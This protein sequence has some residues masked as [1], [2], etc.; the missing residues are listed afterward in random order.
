MG[1]WGVQDLSR[2]RCLGCSKLGCACGFTY[3]V[4]FGC[5]CWVCLGFPWGRASASFFCTIRES[6]SGNP[7]QSF[8]I[9][10]EGRKLLSCQSHRRPTDRPTVIAARATHQHPFGTSAEVKCALFLSHAIAFLPRVHH[11]NLS[12]LSP[13]C[14]IET[15]RNNKILARM[16][17]Y[18]CNA[19][20][21][22]A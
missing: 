14:A 4:C 5:V 13:E 15:C 16:T 19:Y 22:V 17:K 1:V 3:W 7:S 6:C 21:P 11:C 20:D 10:T 18:T 8:L 12:C 9:A 2:V